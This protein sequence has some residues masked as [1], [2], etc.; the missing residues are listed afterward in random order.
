MGWWNRLKGRMTGRVAGVALPAADASAAPADPRPCQRCERQARTL[1]ADGQ[2][3]EAL[4]FAQRQAPPTSSSRMLLNVC[5]SLAGRR[6]DAHLDLLDWSKHSCC[7]MDARLL[8]GLLQLDEGDRAGAVHSLNRNLVQIDDPRTIQALILVHLER[9][10]EA[11]A[12]RWAQRLRG[13]AVNWTDRPMVSAWL[14]AVGLDVAESAVEPPDALVEQ[15]AL[16][17]L[18]CESAISSLE[19]AARYDRSR[20]R[21]ILLL[22]AL[23]SAFDRLESPV[24]ACEAMARLALTLDDP[25]RARRWIDAGLS[26]NPLCAPLAILLSQL[27]SAEEAPAIEPQ[28]RPD[29][30]ILP[31]RREQIE[32]LDLVI[33]AHPDWTDLRLARRRL[34]AA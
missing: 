10:D 27:P 17:L 30:H 9:G 29:I 25:V 2:V 22:A 33:R 21:A 12:R 13:H 18:A 5:R 4:E 20:P 34:E 23:E 15:L 26:L 3:K 7:P 14:A 11:A 24:A 6:V 16:E 8:L 28:R 31:R 32:A 1:L 19:A